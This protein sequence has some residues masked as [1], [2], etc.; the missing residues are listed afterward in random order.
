MK[1]IPFIGLQILDSG[2]VTLVN[3]TQTVILSETQLDTDYKVILTKNVNENVW[4]INKTLNGFTINSSNKNSMA[5]V[6]WAII[7]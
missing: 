4:D 1:Y 5:S 6:D 3:G 2:T 7:E